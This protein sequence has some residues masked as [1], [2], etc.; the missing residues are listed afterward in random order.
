MGIVLEKN[1]KKKKKRETSNALLSLPGHLPSPSAQAKGLESP[2]HLPTAS[3]QV[4]FSPIPSSHIATKNRKRLFFNLQIRQL[5]RHSP[6]FL[7][8]HPQDPGSRHKLLPSRPP[9]RRC[10]SIPTTPFLLNKK[11][12]VSGCVEVSRLG[13][14]A[15]VLKKPRDDSRTLSFNLPCPH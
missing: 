1:A 13:K 15:A 6:P 2:R 5:P 12:R 4:V 9:D 14:S 7:A 8:A 3:Y 11:T 10:N